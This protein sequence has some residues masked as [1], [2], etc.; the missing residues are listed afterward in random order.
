MDRM[1]S[2]VGASAL[3]VAGVIVVLLVTTSLSPPM[4][5]AQTLMATE[6]NRD[7]PGPDPLRLSALAGEAPVATHGVVLGDSTFVVIKVSQRALGDALSQGFAPPPA[8]KHPREDAVLVAF[9]ARTTLHG[10][11]AG[12]SPFDIGAPGLWLIDPC[13]QGLFN[14]LDG[15]A[16]KPGSPNR[17]ALE[18]VRVVLGPG[19]DPVIQVQRIA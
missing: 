19:L 9:D 11:S 16:A 7:D 2:F 4:R 1:R 17:G 18:A 15:G 3:L 14:V 8:T 13:H 12:L 10:C 6:G 5:E